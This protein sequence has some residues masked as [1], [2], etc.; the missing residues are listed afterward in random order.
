M[1][2]QKVRPFDFSKLPKLS[3][4]YLAINEVL[5]EHYP[6]LSGDVAMGKK[7]L[8]SLKDDLK[9]PLTLKYVGMDESSRDDFITSLPSPCV[10]VQIRGEP[11]EEKI[12]MEIEYSFCRRALDLL[13]GGEGQ[14]PKDLRPFTPVEQ[15][16]LECVLLKV[17]G[18]FEDAPTLAGMANFSLIGTAYE[19]KMLSSGAG[20]EEMG[21][22]FKFYL[23]LEKK[24]GYLK[25]YFPHPLVEG[26]LIREDILAGITPPSVA[27]GFEKQLNRVN[28]IKT[29]LWSEVG[30]VS[31][32]ASEMAALEKEDVILFDETLATKDA[33]GL[34]GKALL[35][36]GD[37][38]RGGLLAEVVDSEGK[39]MVLKILDFYGGE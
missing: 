30:R 10:A 9:L 26:T 27:G 6:Q 17:L 16:V 18:Q 22:V 8:Q 36:V 35:R 2:K 1:A 14:T 24:G 23:G 3:H 13:L 39:K 4:R 38:P 32:T 37:Q 34:T 31:L 19:A 28:H 20:Q 12:L 25:V 21:C 7:C 15:A 33:H 11:G 5:L 29:D